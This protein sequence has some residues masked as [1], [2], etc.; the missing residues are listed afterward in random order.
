MARELSMVT[1]T[2]TSK[3]QITVP[4]SVRNEMGLIPGSKVDFIPDQDG[5]WRIVRKKLSI[6]D[7]AGALEYSGKSVTIEDMN[8]AIRQRIADSFKTVQ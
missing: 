6:I 7:L 4:I 5:T 8:K 2:M 3:G 1:A